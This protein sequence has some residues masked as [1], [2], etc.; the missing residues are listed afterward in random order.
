MAA[1]AATLLMSCGANAQILP[2]TAVNEPGRKVLI[3]EVVAEQPSL[4]ELAN[5]LAIQIEQNLE[6]LRTEAD[7][8]LRVHACDARRPR[9]PT[10]FKLDVVEGLLDRDV[11]LEVWARVAAE[12]DASGPHNKVEIGYLIVPVRYFEFNSG[13][14]PG[15]FVIALRSEPIQ[16]IDDLVPLLN[17]SGRIAAYAA[18]ASG[19][20]LL[21]ST[22]LQSRRWDPARTQLCRAMSLL[23]SAGSAR[24]DAEL[25]S[26]A[27][28]LAAQ[29]WSGARADAQYSGFL[30]TPTAV[31]RCLS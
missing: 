8:S 22:S 10:D 26:Y 19:T 14:P 6:Q 31:A 5:T 17:H 1:W 12:T 20:V 13:T 9:A 24:T 4:A 18:L 3:D 11:A 30:K 27:E 16:S 28:E 2:C 21:K 29:A 25:A 15:A 23:R 7:P